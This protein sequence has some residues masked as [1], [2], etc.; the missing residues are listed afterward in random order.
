LHVSEQKFGVRKCKTMRFDESYR[1]V[2]S[3]LILNDQC[4]KMHNIFLKTIVVAA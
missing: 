1:L 2:E 4:G 3:V